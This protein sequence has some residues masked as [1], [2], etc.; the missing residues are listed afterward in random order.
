MGADASK[1]CSGSQADA[2]TEQMAPVSKKDA[3][4]GA[5]NIPGAEVASSKAAQPDDNGEFTITLNKTEGAR[6]GVDVDHHDGVTLLIDAVTGG[7]VQAWNEGN[8]NEQVKQGDRIVAVNGVRGDVMQLVDECKKNQVL[9]MK[10]KR[11]S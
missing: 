6:L 7:L 10:V 8:P 4:P 5:A 3:A 2:S 11:E 9:T 1:C